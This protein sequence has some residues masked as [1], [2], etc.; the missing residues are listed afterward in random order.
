MIALAAMARGGGGARRLG[1]LSQLRR[2]RR[3]G[4]ARRRAAAVKENHEHGENHRC[5]R[6]SRGGHRGRG[7]WYGWRRPD[8]RANTRIPDTNSRWWFG[9]PRHPDV[10]ADLRRGTAGLRTQIPRRHRHLAADVSRVT[11]KPH[12]HEDSFWVWW[13]AGRRADCFQ[14]VDTEK[15]P[16]ARERR[17]GW[18]GPF[19]AA[20]WAAI[21][22]AGN[23]WRK[24]PLAR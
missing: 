22:A 5:R 16:A 15:A 17:T 6:R 7:G 13:P 24:K 18:P 9:V 10:S 14:V 3:V 2:R 20:G 4:T 19:R 12:P 11:P 23:T 8:T 21:P 1:S